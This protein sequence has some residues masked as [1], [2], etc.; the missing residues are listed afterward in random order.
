MSP[1]QIH[2]LTKSLDLASRGS[3]EERLAPAT[4]VDVLV[5]RP[6]EESHSLSNKALADVVQKGSGVSSL[7]RLELEHQHESC[8][9]D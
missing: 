6:S 5:Y 7:G 2:T 8:S 4:A 9:T 3:T 1:T